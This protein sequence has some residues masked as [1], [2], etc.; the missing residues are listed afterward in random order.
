MAL[1]D[2]RR[3]GPP[4]AAE[5]LALHRSVAQMP[6]S[7]LARAA[8][9]LELGY[10]AALLSAPRA[11]SLGAVSEA[12][13]IGEIH[14]SRMEGRQFG[15]VLTDLTVAVAPEFQGRGVG[16]ALFE[17]LFAEA[18]ALSPPISRVELVSRSG[19]AGAIR[20]YQRLGFAIEGCFKG[21]VRLPNGALEDD[22]PM[23]RAL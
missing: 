12:R 18:K 14:A 15:H 11:V 17:R 8:D 3:L 7:G 2:I 4:D 10:F 20:L 16:I 23:A 21:R 6:D 22:V 9:E 13:L 19:N 1:F 5:V